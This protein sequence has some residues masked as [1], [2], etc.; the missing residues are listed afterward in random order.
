MSVPDTEWVED[1]LR[2]VGGYQRREQSEISAAGTE[3]K[4]HIDLVTEVDRESETRLVE[5]L[6]R[7]FPD[8]SILA[9]ED[10]R[11]EGPSGRR[12]IIDPL[13]GTTNYVH[14]HPFFGISLGLEDP[15]G[16]LAGFAYFPRLD[17]F[18][19]GVRNEGAYKNGTRLTL[20][21]PDEPG[22]SFLATGFADMRGDGPRINPEIYLA[23][24]PQVQGIRRGGSAV[25]DLCSLAEG[26]FHGFWEFSLAPWDVAAGMLLVREAG[27]VVSDA[28]GG[29]NW[30]HGGSIVA[31]TQPI[32]DFLL[33]EVRDHLSG[34]S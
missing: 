6:G 3:Y 18:Y 21:G 26:V 2:D 24:L 17:D 1:L 27:G 13:D 7:R 11:R 14:G 5:A 28:H 20:T 15:D 33:T 29:E 31:G 22:D 34:E 23:I 32:H 10:H 25:H 19:S 16:L 9:E 4:G 8:D 30:L 12:W